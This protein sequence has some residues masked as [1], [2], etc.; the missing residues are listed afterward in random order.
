MGLLFKLMVLLRVGLGLAISIEMYDFLDHQAS[1]AQIAYCINGK[2]GLR[3]GPDSE[4]IF[5][6]QLDTSV[7]AN[8]TLGEQRRYTLETIIDPGSGYVLVDHLC[9]TIHLVFRGSK[10]QDDW[11]SDASFLPSKFEPIV[12]KES[13]WKEVW[14][15][16]LASAAVGLMSP[17]QALAKW[18]E[19]FEEGFWVHTGFFA[20]VERILPV[21]LGAVVKAQVNNHGY[22]VEVTGH[23]MGGAVALLCAIEFDLVGMQVGVTTFSA[24]RTFSPKLARFVD[25]RF[26]HRRVVH[27]GDIVPYVPP[28]PIYGH[29]GT[30]M[31]VAKKGLPHAASDVAVRGGGGEAQNAEAQDADNEDEL[32]E[33]TGIGEQLLHRIKK[34]LGSAEHSN[35]LRQLSQCARL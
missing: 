11:L 5:P 1:L 9:C 13:A 31:Y 23:S 19:V 18:S 17:S 16:P 10:T 3:R 12:L 21:V 15:Y 2:G 30:E 25:S 24:P 33:S 27:G 22:T 8:E 4:L 29:S 14:G 26:V 6:S 20:T 35:L 28:R 32:V 34:A 7:D